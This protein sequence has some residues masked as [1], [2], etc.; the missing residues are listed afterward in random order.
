M[1]RRAAPL[2]R[3]AGALIAAG[4]LLAACATPQQRCIS[5][6]TRDLR[7]VNG[8]I[9]EVEVNLARGYGVR[10]ETIFVPTWTYCAPPVWVQQNGGAVLVPGP[11]CMG[12]QAQTINRPV[13]I[14]LAA[15][16]RK[17]AELKEQR[18]R[19]SRQAEPAVAQCRALYPQ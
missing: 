18:S 14:D 1:P 6:A 3:T 11:M 17:L 19:L 4:L 12:N 15:E 16:R 9:E 7:V 5:G 8:L 2:T 13:A 10:Q